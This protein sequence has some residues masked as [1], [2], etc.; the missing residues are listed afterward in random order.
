MMALILSGVLISG[1]AMPGIAYG[2]E[3]YS[4]ESEEMVTEGSVD[5]PEAT[6]SANAG[7]ETDDTEMDDTDIKENTDIGDNMNYADDI[8]ST[9]NIDSTDVPDVTDPISGF[10]DGL[11]VKSPYSRKFP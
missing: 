4:G 11:G 9:D 10:E 2:E 8:Y 6:D 7:W 1:I 3:F 5:S